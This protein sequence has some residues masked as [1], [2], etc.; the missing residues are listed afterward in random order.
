VYAEQTTGYFRFVVEFLLPVVHLARSRGI[1]LSESIPRRVEAGLEFIQSLAPGARDVP[2]IGDSDSGLAIGWQ[3]SDYW[4]FSPLLAAGAVLF[5]RPSLA[6]GIEEFPAESFL[7]LGR[8]G[9]KSFDIML[10][11][12]EVSPASC[13]TGDGI[14]VM[15]DLGAKKFP[16]IDPFKSGKP[17][18]RS[19]SRTGILPVSRGGQGGFPDQATEHLNVRTKT[20][21]TLSVFPLG[22]YRISRD[23]RFGIV[24]DCGSLGIE[25]GYGHGHAD[26]LS[27]L[28]AYRGIPV[29]VD[30]GTGLYN[31]PPKWRAY[32]RSTLAHNTIAVDKGDQSTMIDTFRW[33]RPLKITQEPAVTG[34]GWVLLPGTVQWGRI[35]HRRFIVHLINAGVMVLDELEGPGKHR[36][37]LSFN[38]SPTCRIAARHG[39]TLSIRCGTEYL[40]ASVL[41]AAGG[42]PIVLEGSTRPMGGWYSR[43]YG[44]IE[45]SPTVRLS[46][47]GDLPAYFVTGFKAHGRRVS[48]PRGLPRDL[49]PRGC[50]DLVNSDEFIAFLA[51]N[52]G[53]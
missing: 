30:P 1:E 51:G 25:P 7:L 12:R 32:F 3:L 45:A 10:E 11:D 19:V 41:D 16:L 6:V 33:S 4:D 23:D 14:S 35:V 52:T 31:G 53:A 15:G 13:E 27:Y 26:G 48:L 50:L 38:L 17:T 37:D 46:A 22:G 34:E 44:L 21:C 9:R 20:G 40:E 8:E 29:I 24:F 39:C 49:L 36:L 5:D 18:L 43:H 42:D 2:H 28:L 47:T